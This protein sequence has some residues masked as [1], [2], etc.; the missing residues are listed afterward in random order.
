MIKIP[1]VEMPGNGMW[2]CMCVWCV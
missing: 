1:L 2:C